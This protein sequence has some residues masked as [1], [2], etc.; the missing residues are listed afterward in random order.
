MKRLAHVMRT[1]QFIVFLIVPFSTVKAYSSSV[2]AR[3]D[4]TLAKEIQRQ[5]IA[6]E[7]SGLYYPKSVKRFYDKLNFQSAW[8]KPQKEVGQTWE[9][10]LMLDCVLQFG[11][12]HADYHPTELLYDKL[13]DILD[14]PVKVSIKEQARFEILL[15]DAMIT[16]INNLYYG[17]LNPEFSAYK[18][19]KGEFNGFHAEAILVVALH[20]Q[21]DL[22][23]F[24]AITSVQ[25][26]S[27]EYTDLQYHMHLLTGL[28]QDDCYSIPESDIRL[29]A[30]NMERL[31]WAAIYDSTYIQI[32]IPSY[33]L[34]FNLPYTY[35]QFKIA[36]GKPTTPTPVLSSVITYF[37]T[38]PDVKV[39]QRIFEDQL[40]PNAV[41]DINYLKNNHIAIYDKKGNYIVV[42]PVSLAQIA[43]YP[44]Q[45]FARHASGCDN[46]LGNLVFH[47]PNPFDVDLHD[48]PKLD[49]FMQEER[50]LSNGCIWIADAEKL[51]ELLLKNDERENEIASF[52]KSVLRYQRST[53]LLKRAVPVK[54][55]YL[56][57][58]VIEGELIAYKDIYNL[59]KSL[60]LALYGEDEKLVMK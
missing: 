45:Y 18:I 25:P 48:M 22:D 54:I 15:T 56:T 47:F 7:V 26:K 43:K 24:N 38:A 42:N 8:I 60:E 36:V 1:I 19:D 58:Q 49:F 6:G 55:T 16:V 27:K 41:N 37:T 57:C 40:L 21:K 34:Q 39:E 23:F 32:N 20:Q 44:A 4:S 10:M 11:L 5:L 31:R 53:V 2:T 51:G 12:T 17:K 35:Y 14:T 13:H 59:D 46:A 29:I 9:A 28:Y 33:T 3:P 52:K 30:I 50:D